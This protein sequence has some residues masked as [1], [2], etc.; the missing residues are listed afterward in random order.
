MTRDELLK[1]AI[2]SL[3]AAGALLQQGNHQEG[4][5]MAEQAWNCYFELQKIRLADEDFTDLIYAARSLYEQCDRA[6][7]NSVS[8]E[9]QELAEALKNKEL[10]MKGDVAAALRAEQYFTDNSHWSLLVDKGLFSDNFMQEWGQILNSIINNES[11]P[12][13]LRAFAAY[14]LG[15]IQKLPQFWCVD[16]ATAAK[17]FSY[18]ADHLLALPDAPSNLLLSALNQAVESYSYIGN[19]PEAAKYAKIAMEHG[20]DMGIFF[21]ILQYGYRH[22]EK[23]APELAH[24]MIEAGAWEGWLAEGIETLYQFLDDESEAHLDKLQGLLD[25]MAKY[26]DANPETDGALAC[27]AFV[28]YVQFILNYNL[29]FLSNELMDHL[30]DGVKVNNLHSI[31]YYGVI[32]LYCAELTQDADEKSNFLA[33]AKYYLSIAADRGSRVALINYVCLLENEGTEPGLLESY[34]K[35]ARQY[36]LDV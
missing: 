14:R 29:D 20:A 32:M 22:G 16:M 36:D 3:S 19:I 8:K 33:Q 2:D 6:M 18:A 11:A 5:K 12:K 9:E 28:V 34:K 27:M 15:C 35:S 4:K 30:R 31:A 25:T 26:Y 10:G 13:E 7:A 21:P 23:T 24:A 1:T 17:C